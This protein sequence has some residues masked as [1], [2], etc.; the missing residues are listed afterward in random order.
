MKIRVR[1]LLTKIVSVLLITVIAV[2]SSLFSVDAVE[3]SD[4]AVDP[5]V[6][7]SLGDSYS[8]G[9]GIEPF[10]GDTKR[11]NTSIVTDNKLYDKDWLAHRS[12]KSWPALLHFPGMPEGTSYWGL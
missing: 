4:D 3:S 8:S 11:I 9:E 10:Y 6:V 7:V 5:V 1:K 2:S 12:T